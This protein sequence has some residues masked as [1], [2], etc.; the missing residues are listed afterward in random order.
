MKYG[1]SIRR[2][3]FKID[4]LN[5][6]QKLLEKHVTEL[7]ISISFQYALSKIIFPK[8]FRRAF[9]KNTGGRMLLILSDYSLKI[10]RTPFN[11][12]MPS[13]NK[14]HKYLSKPSIKTSRFV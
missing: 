6:F 4:V 13:G 1:T 7:I 2:S 10:S 12:V 3:S 9:S 14:G 5:I 11:P 8:I